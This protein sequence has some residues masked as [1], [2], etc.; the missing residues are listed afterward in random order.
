MAINVETGGENLN[1][2]GVNVHIGGAVHLDGGGMKACGSDRAGTFDVQDGC[3]Y[4]CD[5]TYWQS[6]N[7]AFDD[8]QAGKEGVRTC[9]NKT[10]CEFDGIHL[11]P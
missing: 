5:G 10:R 8:A 7:V 2:A 9:G 4:F 11:R 3:F 1:P 6:F